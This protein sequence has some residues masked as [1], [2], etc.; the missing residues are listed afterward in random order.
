M[1]QR[2][3]EAVTKPVV[4]PEPFNGETSWED[5]KL[6]FEDVAAV[7][8]WTD[9][10]KLKLNG[11]EYALLDERKR[12]FITYLENHRRHTEEQLQ[13]CKSD[14][15]RRVERPTT[16]LSS[17]P[18]GRNARKDG[19]TSQKIFSLSQIKHFPNWSP[20][21]ESVLLYSPTFGS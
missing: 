16:M 6:H 3:R 18:G 10:Q 13:R 11:F 19:R 9:N 7:N 1:T 15:S 12:H 2:S 8:E 17:R 14:L 21:Q 4:L 20:Q 5:W